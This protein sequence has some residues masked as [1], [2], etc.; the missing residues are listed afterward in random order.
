MRDGMSV[1]I[2]ED[3]ATPSQPAK[4]AEAGANLHEL[5]EFCV[6]RPV[7]ATVLNLLVVLLGVVSF[8][9]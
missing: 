3:K 1:K 5:P 9:A 2:R 4:P 8:H 6:K 7:F